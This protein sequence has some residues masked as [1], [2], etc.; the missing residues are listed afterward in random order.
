MF[1]RDPR[2]EQLRKQAIEHIAV[3]CLNVRLADT[4]Q[5]LSYSYAWESEVR[6]EHIKRLEPTLAIQQIT[7]LATI[8]S[9]GGDWRKAAEV[10][11]IAC[12]FF[13]CNG[14]AYR[15]LEL[16]DS[17]SSDKAWL[18]SNGGKIPGALE[19]W[20]PPAISLQA[21]PLGSDSLIGVDRERL[22]SAAT[23]FY[24]SGVRCD[25]FEKMLVEALLAAETFATVL[26]SRKNPAL[27]LG[28]LALGRLML[29]TWSF[30]WTKG[31]TPHHEYTVLLAGYAISLL[32]LAAVLGLGW[33]SSE[34]Y[35][36]GR[37]ILG[38]LG[39]TLAAWFA[40]NMVGRFVARRIVDWSTHPA[41]MV[42]SNV[43]SAPIWSV[44][45]AMQSAYETARFAHMN[46][47][48]TKAIFSEAVSLGAAFD[49]IAGSFLDRAASEGKH[50]WSSYLGM[51]G[52]EQESYERSFE[53]EP[54]EDSDLE[55]A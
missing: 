18:P 46:P 45:K 8:A 41:K 52:V 36:E 54:S 35:D 22:I 53:L 30:E 29:W 6:P 48:L 3:A 20:R 25:W 37:W 11:A 44:L 38:G 21:T 26:E 4:R 34:L 55:P 28:R 32:K 9:T 15:Q 16:E 24:Y 39:V 13:E 51:R 49:P 47:A 19:L 27:W 40:I 5:T 1:D 12:D 42:M 14:M 23:R 31:K 17:R 2:M 50:A 7:N 10:V 33:Y 43:S